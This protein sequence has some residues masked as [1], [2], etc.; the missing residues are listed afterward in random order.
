MSK[1][2]TK[3]GRVVAFSPVGAEPAYPE[4]MGA[5]LKHNPRIYEADPEA[6]K[7]GITA[8]CDGV[9]ELVA[10]MHNMTNG[11]ATAMVM[12]F[13]RDSIFNR[14]LDIALHEEQLVEM[15]QKQ[16]A[17]RTSRPN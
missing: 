13:I 12:D 6:I 16:S 7:K 11:E 1:K 10:M 3:I 15:A 17:T 4:S 5:I 8:L 14:V 2:A 9:G